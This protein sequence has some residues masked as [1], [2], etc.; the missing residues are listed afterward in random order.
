MKPVSL[1]FTG[2]F[3]PCRNF[4][5]IVLSKGAAIFSDFSEDIAKS[6]LSFVNLECPL[7]HSS[8]PIKKSGPNI[9]AS[10]DCIKAIADIGFDVVGLANNHIMDYGS[11]GL[12]ETLQVCKNAGLAFCGAG[13]NLLESQRPL[14]M[15]KNGARIAILAV[16]EH[17]FSIAGA[18]FP[19]AAPLDPIDNILQIESVRKE[20]DLVFV[21]I[22]GGNEYFPF[23]RPG[24]RKFCKFLIERGADGVICHHPHVPGAY[25]FHQG[26]PI[27]YSLGNLIFDRSHPPEGWNQGYALYLEYD[28]NTKEMISHKVIPYTQ[29]VKQGGV[30]K[31]RGKEKTAFLKKLEDQGRVLSDNNSYNK[32]WSDYCKTMEARVLLR[33]FMPFHFRGL[34]YINKIL[35][36]SK[37]ILPKSSVEVRK[38]LIQCESHRELFLKILNE[39]R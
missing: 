36:I 33:M 11:E 24:L 16:A 27:S 10:P 32:E 35:P 31:M 8:K 20:A 19:G 18:N 9:K 39:K 13:E 25:E 7:S 6:D 17:E 14:V 21:T 22:H 34:R 29:S 5:S 37:C 38:N 23:P 15:E 1:L 12:L 26:K 28:V 30:W 2:D 4:E 3:A